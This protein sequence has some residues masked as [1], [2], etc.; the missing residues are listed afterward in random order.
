[1]LKAVL[2][3]MDGVLVDTEPE[4]QRLDIMLAAEMGIA[5]TPKDQSRYVGVSMQEAWR[6]MQKRYGFTQ[7]PRLICQREEAMIA[8]HYKNGELIVYEG[9]VALL[10]SCAASGLLVAV[11]TSSMLEHAECVIN[12]LGLSD[13]VH[14]VASSCMTKKSKPAPDIFLLAMK[15]LGVNGNE[16]IVIEDADSGVTAAHAAG[17]KRVIGIRH[18]GRWQRLTDADLV[19]DS[20]DEMTVQ[21]LR[22]LME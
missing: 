8:E 12:R 17:V 5:L 4:Y 20:L 14:A 10:E 22:D 3:D 15:M 11:A 16:C 13:D 7:D 19:V 6:D 9:A 1:M 18:K 21:A 2:F